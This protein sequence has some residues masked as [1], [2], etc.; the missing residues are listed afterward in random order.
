M[1]YIGIAVDED[2]ISPNPILLALHSTTTC[3]T[4]FPPLGRGSC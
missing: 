2:W 3:L 4:P 1:S